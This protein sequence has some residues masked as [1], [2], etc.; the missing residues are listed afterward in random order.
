MTEIYTDKLF[1]TVFSKV[2][3]N[4]RTYRIKSGF[5]S[6]MLLWSLLTNILSSMSSFSLFVILRHW[7]LQKNHYRSSAVATTVPAFPVVL[8]DRQY[9]RKPFLSILSVRVSV[10]RPRSVQLLSSFE[11]VAF[12]S[13]LDASSPLRRHRCSNGRRSC[14]CC[15]S[16]AT[17]TVAAPTPPHQKTVLPTDQT[18]LLL[19][20]PRNQ[21]DNKRGGR[22]VG[23]SLWLAAFASLQL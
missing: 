14:F 10:D 5:E 15:C 2:W 17:V 9:V 12:V 6:V 7:N 20:L 23:Q 3:I 18:L 22:P 11:P 13:P 16:T 19:A 1:N 21:S 4:I 8:L